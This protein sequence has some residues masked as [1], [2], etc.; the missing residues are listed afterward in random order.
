MLTLL[1]TQSWRFGEGHDL[2]VEVQGFI[3]DGI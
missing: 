1:L 3:L 2:K